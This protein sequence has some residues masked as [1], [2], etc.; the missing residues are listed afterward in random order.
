MY[1]LIGKKLG[2]SFSPMLHRL[3]WGCADYRLLELD[4]AGAERFF[5]A[6]DFA[7]VNVTIPY[8]RLALRCC[9]WVDP[10]AERTGAVNTVVNRSGRLYGYNTDCYGMARCLSRAGISLAGRKVLLFGS[11][12]TS[13]T[14][15]AVCRG[16]GAREVVVVSRTGSTTYADLPRHRDAE[17]LINCTPLGMW[18]DTDGMCADPT[19]FPSC[20][21]VMD[22]VYNPLE[23]RLV[24][25]A[26]LA[27]IPA[28]CGLPMLAGQ[29][30]LAAELFSGR[31]LPEALE[32]RAVLHMEREQCNIVLIGM[33]GCGK[34]SVGAGLA[35]LLGRPLVDT[36][37]LVERAAG[38]SVPE[39]FSKYGEAEFRR[40][41]AAAVRE[42][43]LG[44]G[45][46]IAC[47]GGAP[48][49]EENRFHLRANGWVYYLRRDTSA[50]DRSAR[51]LSAGGRAVLER[52]FAQRHPIY[53]AL[54]RR[55]VDNNGPLPQAIDD[56]A[57][58]F[59]AP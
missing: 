17:V 35:R 19:G 54:C 2:H 28:T 18:P 49:T 16:E 36:D 47:G 40:L 15:Q 3:L 10:A 11:G 50:L 24:R 14:A 8:K 56:I 21:G 31:A 48:L 46:V 37:A 7:G 27:G 52:L 1:G 9:D 12:G 43:G 33:P 26:R 32:D 42:A 41:E 29:A 13:L 34:S 53:S 6:R 58:E 51:P 23:T 39:I 44:H 55:E 59:L 25:R 57:K 30:R 4:E 38:M 45:T 22:A 5:A 20:R